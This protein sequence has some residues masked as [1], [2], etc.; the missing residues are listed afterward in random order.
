M[1]VCEQALQGRGNELGLPAR[2]RLAKF[3]KYLVQHPRVS[4]VL[5]N[6]FD[7]GRDGHG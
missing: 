4:G 5:L 1:A 2:E 7:G 3:A 6:R